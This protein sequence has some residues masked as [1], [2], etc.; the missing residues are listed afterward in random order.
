MNTA[1][2][3]VSLRIEHPFLDLSFVPTSLGMQPVRI[4]KIGDER[5]TPTGS[6]LGGRRDYSYC[7]V[8][9]GGDCNA[10]LEL[11]IRQAI[12]KIKSHRDTLDQVTTTGGTVGFFIGWFSHGDSGIRIQIE[13]LRELCSLNIQL[14][15]NVYCCEA[16]L[17]LQ[18]GIDDNS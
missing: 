6:H 15:I 10:A 13:T 2:Y 16:E 1:R 9:M 12:S 14:D 17:D 7:M 5:V 18:N 8:D 3:K 11:Q 4:W